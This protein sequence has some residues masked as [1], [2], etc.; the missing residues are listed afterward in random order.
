VDAITEPLISRDEWLLDPD[1]TFLNH[2][3]FGAVPRAVLWHQ[4]ML[5]ERMERNPTSFLT[6]ELPAALRSAAEKL[7]G[8]SGGRGEDYVFVENATAGCNAVLN[9]IRF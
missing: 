2:G 3:S 5:L 4:K 8:F 6:Y 1:I 9:S 7:A